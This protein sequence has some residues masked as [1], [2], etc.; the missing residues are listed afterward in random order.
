MPY[1]I[2]GAKPVAHIPD[3]HAMLEQGMALHD[4]L[5]VW[6]RDPSGEIHNWKPAAAPSAMTTS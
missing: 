5:Y 3:D 1:D 2:P 4:A 6:C